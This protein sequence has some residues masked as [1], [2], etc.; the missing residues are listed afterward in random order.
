M[1]SL[2]LIRKQRSSD[3]SLTLVRS[4]VQV[5][6]AGGCVLYID[7]TRDAGRCESLIPVTPLIIT[8]EAVHQDRR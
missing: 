3:L 6:L 1:L 5:D 4:R 2:A 7:Q 8:L